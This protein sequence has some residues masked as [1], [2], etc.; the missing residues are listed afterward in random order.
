MRNNEL[1]DKNIERLYTKQPKVIKPEV[2]KGLI[3]YLDNKSQF[4]ANYAALHSMGLKLSSNT[5][6]GANRV[7]VSARQKRNGTSWTQNGS[8][9]AL[10]FY[11]TVKLN[12]CHKDKFDH[13]E[14][15]LTL[16]AA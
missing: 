11:Y 9:I 4:L 7:L 6:E 5:A 12:N 10:A 1:L 15:T 16:R 2:I 14:I 8:G 13:N 3:K